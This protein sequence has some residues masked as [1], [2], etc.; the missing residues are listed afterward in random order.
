MELLV[1]TQVTTCFFSCSQLT[2]ESISKYV[3]HN[4]REFLQSITSYLLQLQV[5][6]ANYHRLPPRWLQELPNWASCS[7]SY[8]HL[9]FSPLKKQCNSFQTYIKM[10]DCYN[11]QEF[12]HSTRIPSYPHPQPLSLFHPPSTCF[13]LLRLRELLFPLPGKQTD[14]H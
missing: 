13:A 9:T 12:P 14:T 7:H 4:N 2:S 11:L 8:P 3:H 1:W 6:A 5:K 10:C